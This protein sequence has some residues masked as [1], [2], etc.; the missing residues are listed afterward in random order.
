MILYM[1]IKMKQVGVV[2]VRHAEKDRLMELLSWVRKNISDNSQ[3]SLKNVSTK[4][5]FS[6][7][8]VGVYIETYR[9]EPTK[10]DT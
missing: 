1:S 4:F 5:H 2:S 8:Y 6:P 10:N 9:Y 7:N 3:L